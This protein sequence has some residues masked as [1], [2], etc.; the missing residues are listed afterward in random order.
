MKTIKQFF[1]KFPENYFIAVL[2]VA[3]LKP[4]FTH[5]S[6]LLGAACIVIFQMIVMNGFFGIIMANVFLILNSLLLVALISQLGEF[7]VFNQDAYQL[8]IG[9]SL[10]WCS[11]VFFAILMIRKYMDGDRKMVVAK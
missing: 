1:A 11:N 5:N 4:P 2:L 6:L 3:A 7:D 8:L 10:I 9:G